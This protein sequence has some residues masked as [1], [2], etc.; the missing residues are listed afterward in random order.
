MG[1]DSGTEPVL[2]ALV[3]TTDPLEGGAPLVVRLG[4]SPV[5]VGRRDV[6]GR[7]LADSSL[8]GDAFGSKNGM[9]AA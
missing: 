9:E 2:P 6:S 4:L 8:G 3:F 5:L 1:M 7:V